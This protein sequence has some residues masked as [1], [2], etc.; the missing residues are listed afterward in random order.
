MKRFLRRALLQGR[1]STVEGREEEVALERE[2]APACKNSTAV[3]NVLELGICEIQ[4]LTS[5]VPAA[6]QREFC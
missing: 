6:C 1:P 2:A 4:L 5:G 3:I